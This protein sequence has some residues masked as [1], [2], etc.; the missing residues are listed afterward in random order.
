MDDELQ[1]HG[2][3]YM[4]IL[5]GSLHATFLHLN[6]SNHVNMPAHPLHAASGFTIMVCGRKNNWR[7]CR[8]ASSL[9]CHIPTP[10]DLLHGK[11]GTL[12][13]RCRVTREHMNMP[14]HP[15]H[16]DQQVLTR[17]VAKFQLHLKLCA[18]CFL[19][20]SAREVQNGHLLQALWA[21]NDLTSET[22]QNH[23]WWEKCLT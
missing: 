15:L 5:G 21:R 22:V 19:I 18:T 11:S 23:T 3:L 4:L 12:P 13:C 1:N 2:I 9:N 10:P 8:N 16:A 7:M 6:K 17:H 20:R 14:A